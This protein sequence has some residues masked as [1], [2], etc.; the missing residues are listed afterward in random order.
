MKLTSGRLGVLGTFFLLQ[1][2]RATLLL[3]PFKVEGRELKRSRL[4]HGLGQQGDLS[5]PEARP[6]Y[7]RT[8]GGTKPGEKIE[9]RIKAIKVS[10]EAET[11]LS[12]SRAGEC[13]SWPPVFTP[14][15]FHPGTQH[16]RPTSAGFSRLPHTDPRTP[17]PDRS[18]PLAHNP[19]WL[20]RGLQAGSGQTDLT[21]LSLG[22]RC[23]A[24]SSGGVE[25]SN[26][27]AS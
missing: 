17:D 20:Q 11:L 15:T 19:P 14:G 3:T 27:A 26:K 7:L 25:Q 24:N 12:H 9:G 21:F 5:P 22:L 16:W 2:R 18:L 6:S 4:A 23:S 1:G 10:E 8:S 13:W